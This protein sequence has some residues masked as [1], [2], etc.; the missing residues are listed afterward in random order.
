M[1]KARDVWD[2]QEE[3]KQNR[4]AAMIPVIAQIQAKWTCN[5]SSK[6]TI[7]FL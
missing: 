7:M 5:Q 3:R 1:L 2:E 6:K 4:M